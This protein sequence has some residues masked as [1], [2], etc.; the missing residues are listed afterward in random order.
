MH[1]SLVL[2]IEAELEACTRDGVE[3]KRIFPFP[4][5]CGRKLVMEFGPLIIEKLDSLPIPAHLT[6][7]TSIVI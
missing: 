5:L 6:P 3:S 2:P 4:G 1:C 7:C